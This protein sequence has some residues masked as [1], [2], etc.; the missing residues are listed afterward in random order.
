LL[1]CKGDF[2]LILRGL[3][4]SRVRS[5]IAQPLPPVRPLN[6]CLVKVPVNNQVKFLHFSGGIFHHLG[7]VGF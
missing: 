4:P 1:D 6:A 7:R 2:T 3:K 5:R